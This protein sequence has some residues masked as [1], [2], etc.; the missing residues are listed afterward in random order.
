[1]RASQRAN[2]GLRGA[3]DAGVKRPVRHLELAGGGIGTSAGTDRAKW[4]LGLLAQSF[5][6]RRTDSSDR[7][8]E[9][10]DTEIEMEGFPSINGELYEL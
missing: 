1:M 3:S 2:Q 4:P 9:I 5:I 6:V 10:Y 7:W 8:C